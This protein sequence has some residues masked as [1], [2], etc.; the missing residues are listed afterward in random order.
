MMMVALGRI[1][2]H[3]FLNPDPFDI[4]A[5]AFIIERSGGRV[6]NWDGHPWSPF[7]GPIVATNG[8]LHDAVLEILP[9]W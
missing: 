3:V 4:A 8:R 1:G 9:R 6:T 7:G 2:G 5:A